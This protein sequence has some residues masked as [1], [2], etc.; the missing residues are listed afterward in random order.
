MI[1]ISLKIVQVDAG[2][3]GL[4]TYKLGMQGGEKSFQF[5]GFAAIGVSGLG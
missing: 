5:T 3:L 4:Q 1:E 2:M